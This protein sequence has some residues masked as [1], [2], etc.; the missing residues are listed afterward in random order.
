MAKAKLYSVEG[1]L[2]SEV[3]LEATHF[4][5]PVDSGLIHLGVVV[6][7]GNARQGTAKTKGRS[8]VS[9]TG[10]KPWK[11]KGTGRARAGSNTSPIWVRGGKA[12]GAIPRDYTRKLNSKTKRKILLGALTAK[13]A[14]SRISIFEKF[15]LPEVKT[16]QLNLLLHK[17]EF[18][19]NERKCI[20]VSNPNESLVLSARNL[21]NVSVCSV[22]LLN[23]YDIVLTDQL[24][25][26][27]EAMETFVGSDKTNS[28]KGGNDAT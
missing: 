18:K 10:K 14:E 24:I 1:T 9:G 27:Q 5:V 25:F 13:A 8:E 28:V 4:D 2:K 12:H 20:L 26:T 17:A 11:Q 19:N 7:R 23:L 15:E 22:Q 6:Q 3:E 16:K 21:P